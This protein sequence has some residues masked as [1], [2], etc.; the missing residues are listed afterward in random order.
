MAQND[1]NEKK[2]IFSGFMSWFKSTSTNSNKQK[3][4]SSWFKEWM[5]KP[6]FFESWFSKKEPEVNVVAPVSATQN[7]SKTELN[8]SNNTLVGTLVDTKQNLVARG[9]QLGVVNEKSQ[10]L[11][12]QSRNTAE[13]FKALREEMQR[14]HDNSWFVRAKKAVF[15]TKNKDQQEPENNKDDIRQEVVTHNDVNEQKLGADNNV[16][17][18]KDPKNA[19]NYLN[20]SEKVVVIDIA[21]QTQAAN[22]AADN[23]SADALKNS[24]KEQ[25][26]SWFGNP[27]S[28]RGGKGK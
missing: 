21:R 6:W 5:N 14:R 2:G 8:Q 23:L 27:F 22:N 7:N 4:G 16:Q 26:A 17:G 24:K 19:I 9:K 20:D 18:K 3:S 10:N 1:T 15:G 25:E 28:G 12:D 13:G 11:L